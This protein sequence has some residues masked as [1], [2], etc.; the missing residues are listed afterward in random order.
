[1]TVAGNDVRVACPFCGAMNDIASE[2]T[3]RVA[4]KLEQLGIRVPERPMSV[5]DIEADFARK[6]AEE[7]Q[8]RRTAIFV[9]PVLTAVFL[10]ILFVVLLAAS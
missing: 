1:M 3:V 7:R 10:V 5:S 9:A 8:K 2:G 6:A 4:K